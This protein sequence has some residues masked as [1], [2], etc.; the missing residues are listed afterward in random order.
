MSSPTTYPGVYIREIPSGVRPITGVATSITAFIGPTLSGPTDRAT[1]VNGFADFE[2]VFGGISRISPLSFA[3]HSFFLNGGGQAVV[4]RVADANAARATITLGP[5]TL[6]ASGPGTWGARLT[7]TVSHQPTPDPTVAAGLGVAPENLFD[8]KIVLHSAAP[9]APDLTQEL[10]HNLAVAA[11]SPR[12]VT[13]VLAAESSLVRVVVGTPASTPAAISGDGQGGA[14]GDP[15]ND[16]SYLGSGA[17]R[18]G[19]RALDDTDLFNLL[20]IPPRSF[21]AGV[22][23][24]ANVYRT[25]AA[26]CRERRAVLLVD[27]PT[28]MTK[29]ATRARTTLT[30]LG[31][32]ALDARN[33]ALYFPRLSQPDPTAEG[34]ARTFVPCGVVAGVIARTDATRGVW[35]APAGIDA[36]LAGVNDLTMGADPVNLTDA[37]NGDLNVLGIN[38]LRTFPVV[39]RVVWGARTLRGADA[40]ADEYKYLPVRRLALYL[41]ESLYRGTQWVVFEPN[42]EPLWAQ[43]RL[44]IGAFLQGLFRQG[45]FEGSSPR[46]AYFVKCDAETTTAQDIANGRVNI[47]VGFAPVRPAEF[48]ILQIQQITRAQA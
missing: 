16:A 44:N 2:R 12:N 5:L 36:G 8:L 39:G 35:K 47:V 15:P 27:P 22:D 20:C 25:A 32:P 18:T 40:L 21:D 6:E 13:H 24:S 43:I 45:A 48:V 26:Y 9:G 33:A 11:D 31:L 17:A 41:E 28:D 4:V 30:N 38:C 7:A 23:T 14:D 46:D 42:D 10:F 3:V 19:L 29:D 37:E 1:T 34:R